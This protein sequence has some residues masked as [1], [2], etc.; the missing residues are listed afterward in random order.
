MSTPN[1]T[2]EIDHRGIATVTLNRPE[3]HNAFDD[4]VVSEL[5]HA[6]QQ[7]EA[8]PNA[9]AM[10]LT[11]TGK[12]FSAGADLTWMQRMG[13]YSYDNN[14]EDAEA[15]AQMLRTLNELPK[16]TIARIQGSAWGGA[17]GLI[18]CCD[19]AV[20]LDSAR[21]CFSEVRLGLVPATISPHVIT[22][23]GQRAARRYFISAESMDAAAAK[24]IGLV[25]EVVS[26]DELDSVLEGWLVA[27]LR[28]GPEAMAVAKQLIADVGARPLS[29]ELIWQTSECIA[30]LR[31]S[32][33]GR[34]GLA[35]FLEKRSPRWAA[36]G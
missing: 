20:A 13:S 27:L 3:K 35:A 21:F 11:A 12:Y 34:E 26:E 22:A 24:S 7:V 9:R 23:I 14:L 6:F 30:R 15:L 1:V 4:Q 31:V 28:N 19:M 17:V 33:E 10:V 8:N 16:P 18:C 2:T 32:G 29:D 25:N 5:T 36:K